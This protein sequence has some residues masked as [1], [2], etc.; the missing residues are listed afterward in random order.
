MKNINP[1]IPGDRVVCIVSSWHTIYCEDAARNSFPKKGEV[2]TV[3][4]TRNDLVS[5]SNHNIG[6]CQNWF[7]CNCFAPVQDATEMESDE[8]EFAH[9][10]EMTA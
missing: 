7:K 1:F 6:D 9:Y 2:L 3:D 5:F 8:T 10:E 4:K